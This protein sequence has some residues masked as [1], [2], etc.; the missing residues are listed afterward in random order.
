MTQTIMNR[1]V[2]G[3]FRDENITSPVKYDIFSAGFQVAFKP[4]GKLVDPNF[5]TKFEVR[6]DTP[7]GT[8]EMM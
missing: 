8:G 2:I 4:H 6:Y 5:L 3:E 7:T 1:T